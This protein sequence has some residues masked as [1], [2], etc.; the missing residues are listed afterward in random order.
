MLWACLLLPRLALDAVQRRLVDDAHGHAF[1]LITG[2]AQR[3]VLLD[4]NAAARA[5]GLLP[6]Q[7]LLAAQAL[8]PHVAVLEHDP[9][10]DAA[11]RQLLAAWAYR[12]SSMVCLQGEDAIV[13][14]VQG[15]LGLFGPWP[16]LER[17]LR[18]DLRE[19][20]IEH[21]IALA[22]TPLGAGVLAAG[23]DGM[24]IADATQLQRMLGRAPI[25]DARL[26]ETQVQA[27]AAMGLRR[28]RQLFELPRAGLARR[29]GEGLLLHLDRLRGEAPDPREW[30]RPPDAFERR[31]EFNHEISHHPALLF[32][33]RRLVNDL[34]AYL[35]GRDGGVQRFFMVLEHE[36][37]AVIEGHAPRTER[38]P[39]DSEVA[40]GLLAPERDPARLFELARARLEQ[41][42]IPAPVRALRLVARELPPFVPAGRDLF[43]AR[44]AQALPWEA[45]RERLRARLGPQALYQLA[46]HADPRPEQATRRNTVLVREPEPLALPARPAWLLPRP[47]PL[48]DHAL[49]VLAGP[50][51][52]ESGWWDGGDVR[53]DYYLVE[54]SQGQRA[55]AFLP[56][57]ETG[58][59]W[60][61]HG[62]FA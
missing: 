41:C 53:R 39:P 52:I 26:P 15:S 59:A 37:M 36:D 27:M 9:R 38:K 31:I 40:V 22:P 6:G 12:Y 10:E 3:R 30:Y 54:T 25:A 21:R 17:L 51:R 47:L 24:A 18:A 42:R 23:A 5:A 8:L 7:P 4:A 55:W 29:F 57:G 28:L 48:R 46:G 49:R 20:G 43:D 14:E 13:L 56:A 16:R 2:P 45:L 1:A 60:M 58:G 62:W 33:L 32:P 61:L 34:G 44:P 11:L 19:L 35:A 50:E